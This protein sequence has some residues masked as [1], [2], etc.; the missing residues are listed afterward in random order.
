MSQALDDAVACLRSGGVIAYPT[1]SVYGLG[2]D[3][4]NEQAIEK[5]LD[6]KQRSADKGLILIAA[7][8]AQLEPWLGELPAEKKH[9]I[10]AS[11]PGP[12]SWLW[13]AREEISTLLRGRHDTLAVRVTAHPQAAALCQAFGGAIV[14]TSA[15]LAGEPAARTPAQV[16]RQFGPRLDYIL[17]GELGG[18]QNPSEIRDALSGKVI[19]ES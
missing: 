2:C 14:S 7:S 11:W 5:L 12:V 1:E 10:L 3:P 19:R 17:E 18:R 15:N 8:L 9:A 4:A 6:L 16:T 13:P